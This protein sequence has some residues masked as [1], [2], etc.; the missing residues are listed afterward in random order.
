MKEKIKYKE[1][2]GHTIYNMNVDGMKGY[3]SEKKIETYVTKKE[4]HAMIKA[5]YKVY[6]VPLFIIILGFT[7][8]LLLIYFLWLK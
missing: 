4:K 2:D 1:D 5:A 3:K 6:F 7:V 8:A